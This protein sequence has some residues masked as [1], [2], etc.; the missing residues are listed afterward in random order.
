GLGHPR[1]A[2]RRLDQVLGLARLHPDAHPRGRMALQPRR[3][4]DDGVHRRGL[5]ARSVRLTAQVLAVGLVVALLSLLVWRFANGS[6]KGVSQ[7]LADGRHPTAPT[8]DLRRLD[9]RG[10]IDLAALTGKKP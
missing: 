10:R 7:E 2:R 3:G 4:R 5:M 9:G 6:D 8:F 1:H